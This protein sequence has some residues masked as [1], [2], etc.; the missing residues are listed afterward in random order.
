[1]GTCME[2]K[3]MDDMQVNEITLARHHFQQRQYGHRGVILCFSFLCSVL[4]SQGAP[5]ER[6][7]S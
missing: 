6:E 3:G 1:M 4:A 7:P 2:W 5:V